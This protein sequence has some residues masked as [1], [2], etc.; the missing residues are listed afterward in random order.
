M[1]QELKK[2]RRHLHQNPELSTQEHKT[3]AYVMQHLQGLHFERLDEVGGTG[4]AVYFKGKQAGNKILL[5]GDMDALPIQEV[6]DFEHKSNTPGVSHKCG[7]DGHTTILLGVAQY[8]SKNPIERG[9]VCLVFQPAEENGKGAKAILEDKDFSF[10]ADLAFA[11]HNL[12]AYPLHQVVCRQNNFNA[13]ARSVIFKFKGKTAH[14]AQPHTGINP[15][16]AISETIQVAESLSQKNISQEDF[17]LISFIHLAMGEKAYGVSAGF[18]E[19]HLT[20]R[21]WNN[22]TMDSLKEKLLAEVRAIAKKHNLGVEEEW[23]EIFY[24]NQNDEKAYSI[25]RKSAKLLNLDYLD[26]KEPFTWGEDFGL[27]TEA[28]KGAMFG[29][30]SGENCPA[31]HNPDYDYPDEITETGVNMFTQILK[32][33]L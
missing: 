8:L 2:F 17:Q 16:L 10:K 30:G 21:T 12:P 9:E 24:A 26:R 27:F 11:L 13:A 3:Q 7:H 19:V 32:N 5:R 6:N 1:Y 20:L 23:L 28:F 4:L 25:I 29:I 15:A 14:A 18:G 22:P 33:A 31:L